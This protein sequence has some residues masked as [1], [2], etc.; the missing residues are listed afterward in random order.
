MYS[1]YRNDC[2]SNM[3]RQLEEERYARERAEDLLR[4]N[5]EDLARERENRTRE[6]MRAYE[7]RA[8]T[9]TT[10]PEALRKQAALF[11][12]EATIS[13][14]YDDSIGDEFR[15]RQH[16]CE[17]ALELWQEEASQLNDQLE[18]LKVQ[19]DALLNS[20]RFSVADRLEA[21]NPGTAK[22]VAQALRDYSED[23]DLSEW[24]RW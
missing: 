4:Q 22:D 24:L 16:A 7:E 14:G 20:I 5:R 15:A 2:D 21:E 17:R 6:R 9:A 8:R 12:R 3:K 23:D 10:W 1:Y 13:C 11:A 19:L 18:A